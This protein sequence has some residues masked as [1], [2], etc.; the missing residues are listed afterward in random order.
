MMVRR[1]LTLTVLMIAFLNSASAALSDTALAMH[2]GAKYQS[3]Y[4][5][6]DYAEPEAAQGG[7]LRL[8]AIGTFNSLNPFLVRGLPAQGLRLV[9]QSLLSRAQDEPFTLYAN[10]AS[11]FDITPDR[12]S[13]TYYLDKQARFSN[14]EPLTPQDVLFTYETLRTKGRPNHRQY[15]GEVEKAE[16]INPEAVRFTFTKTAGRELPLILSLMPI[17]SKK[18]FTEHTFKE[19]SLEPPIGTGPYRITSL[20]PGR[21]ITY[22]KIQDYWGEGRPQYAGRH[23]FDKITFEY[24]RDQDIAFEALLAGEVDVFFESD[25]SKWANK[26]RL[27]DK[28]ILKTTLDFQLPAPLQAL[29]FNT[30]KSYFEDLNVRKA[31][32]LVYDFNWVNKNL[33]HGLYKRT[34]SYFDGSMLAATGIPNGAELALLQPFKD[35]LPSDLFEHPFTLSKTDGSGR[36]RKQLKEARSLLEKSG[37]VASGEGL[38]HKDTGEIFNFEILLGDRQYL[39]LLSAFQANLKKLGISVNMRVVDSANYQN[40]INNYEFDMIVVEWGQSLSPGNEQAFYWSSTAGTTPGS[41]NYPGI[42]LKSVDFLVHKIATAITRTELETATRA[43]DRILLWNNYSIPLQHTNQQWLYHWPRISLPKETSF[44]G[45]SLDVWW[46][47]TVD[48]ARK[49]TQ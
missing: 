48:A 21:Y 7:H 39:K 40:R 6:F 1:L 13:I 12:R 17:M 49:K 24:F 23:N 8:P 45:T 9:Y 44:Y 32:G 11:H 46:D 10:L 4:P 31:I 42:N 20:E 16:I 34:S 37:W 2:G 22:E 15:Y 30:R 26:E 41:R 18:Y 47:G 27:A 5:H 19:T 29:A 25:P 14:G 3:D 33:L 38:R 35:E 36:N 28:P 43:L